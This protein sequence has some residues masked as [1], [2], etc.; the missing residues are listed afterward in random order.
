MPPQLSSAEPSSAQLSSAQLSSAQLSSAQL[1]PPPPGPST[2]STATG[3]AAA[4]SQPHPVAV[5]AAP[6]QP[7]LQPPAALGHA[8]H[9]AGAAVTAVAVAVAVAAA[10][11]ADDG[12]VG[13]AAAAEERRRGR[14]EAG[15]IGRHLHRHA[16]GG[17][18]AV[19]VLGSDGDHV[20]G[21][22][23]PGVVRLQG[24]GTGRGAGG[25][26]SLGGVAGRRAAGGRW[27]SG[28]H[29]AARPA[30]SWAVAAPRARVAVVMMAA[31]MSE[32]PLGCCA[33]TTEVPY[34]VCGAGRPMTPGCP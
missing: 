6:C 15:R 1:T 20:G 34:T 2:P 31:N 26:G 13:A 28:A 17:T 30:G 16:G 14:D 21:A 11:A 19:V 3:I 32:G 27:A 10:A 8:Q 9:P 29:R 12:G 4:P 24:Q 22:R 25:Q 7:G 23:L 18:H 33:R 5:L